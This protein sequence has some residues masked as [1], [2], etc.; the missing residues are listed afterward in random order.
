MKTIRNILLGLALA[1]GLSRANAQQYPSVTTYQPPLLVWA[2][3][4]VTTYQD[5][6][7][8]LNPTPSTAAVPVQYSPAVTLI[9]HAWNTTSTAAD[10][11]LQSKIELRPV[12]ASTPTAA[13]FWSFSRSATGTPTYT[14]GMN[15]TSA[16]TLT[17]TTLSAGTISGAGVTGAF[18][19]PPPLGSTTPNTV[20]ATTLTTTGTAA[21]GG[22]LASH[23]YN[24]FST[25]GQTPA[26]ATRTVVTGSQLA[27]P[28]ASLQVGTIIHWHLDLTKTA[29]GTA[30]STFD[31]AAGTAGTTGDAAV[32][33]FTKPA[34]TAAA[35]EGTI[36]IEAVVKTAGASGVVLGNFAM[37]HNLA[38]TG[39]MVIP[40]ASVETTSSTTNLATPTFVE[41]CITT[42]AA[43]AV[44][45]NQCSVWALNL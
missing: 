5:G 25:S 13:I 17:V 4:L 28:A 15:L 6:F 12:S 8:G 42:G 1:V 30:A 9:G 45:I 32:V 14:D 31:V 26:A 18:A 36:D 21:L 24:A 3:G 16:G 33:S 43:D 10:N 22:G 19:S 34:G 23:Y 29:A 11:F 7:V 2:P 39:H 20:A 40:C 37:V 35:D 44:T 41:L 27:I 38:S